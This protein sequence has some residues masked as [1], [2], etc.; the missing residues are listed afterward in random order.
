[1]PGYSS[2]VI[3]DSE[4]GASKEVVGFDFL[5]L[6]RL[7][8]LQHQVRTGVVAPNWLLDIVDEFLVTGAGVLHGIKMQANPSFQQV[9]ARNSLSLRNTIYARMN[10]S[11][12]QCYVRNPTLFPTLSRDSFPI[13]DNSKRRYSHSFYNPNFVKEVPLSHWQKL[14]VRII[15]GST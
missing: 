3:S 7:L 4:Q 12:I 14:N 13:G 10:R 8:D 5:C 15:H 6:G 2:N 11:T 1:M 9:G